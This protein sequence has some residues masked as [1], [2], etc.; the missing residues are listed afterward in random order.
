M[1]Y[2]LSWVTRLLPGGGVLS[3]L[4]PALLAVGAL[5]AVVLTAA[6]SEAAGPPPDLGSDFNLPSFFLEQGRPAPVFAPRSPQ[7]LPTP[8]PT[9]TATPAPTT[10]SPCENGVVVPADI[11]NPGL[12]ADCEL[13]WAMKQG[14]TNADEKLNWNAETSI[15]AWDGIHCLSSNWRVDRV[16]LG[17]TAYLSTGLTISYDLTGTL[18]MPADL[19]EAGG[20]SEAHQFDLR[21]N[22]LEGPIPTQLGSL[23]K[24]QILDLGGN[25]FTGSIPTQLGNLDLLEDLSLAHNRLSGSI[26]T[27]LG[28]LV[29]L[30][31][32]HLSYNQLSGSIPASLGSLLK[33]EQLDLMD[34]R[35]TGPIPSQLGNLKNHLFSLTLAHNRLSGTIPA[36]LTKLTKLDT[37]WLEGGRFS[38][39]IPVALQNIEDHD[40]HSL[41]INFCVEPGKQAQADDRAVL[42]E[43]YNSTGGENWKKQWNWLSNLPLY[44]W[45]GIG[46]DDEGRVTVVNLSDAGLTGALPASLGNLSKLEWLELSRNRELTGSLPSTIGKLSNLKHLEIESTQLS[47]PLHASLGNLTKLEY[48]SFNGSDLTGSVPASLGNLS[49]LEELDLVHNNLTGSI[50]S[51]LGKLSKLK[52]LWV[53][54]NELTSIP[55]ELG[56]LDNLES[57]SLLYNPFEDDSCIPDGLRDVPYHDLDFLRLNFCGG[58]RPGPPEG[59]SPWEWGY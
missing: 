12:L 2:L 14:F 48:I 13:L 35:L 11:S 52:R 9:P 41:D 3:F 20:L 33:L 34:N 4:A 45:D 1:M 16:D 5:I 29:D 18:K 7:S 57:V 15:L 28:N 59:G 44:K 47:G 19:V 23:D 39:C 22:H 32:L 21:Q 50:P 10:E 55:S 25:N 30:E 58:G 24:L 26:P 17:R 53:R 56:N 36:S 49:Q 42:V 37:L 38:G 43:L 27:S 31:E 51:E 40:L 46:T 6:S 8:T 54:G